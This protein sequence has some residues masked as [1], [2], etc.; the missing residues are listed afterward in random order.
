M[1]FF[2]FSLFLSVFLIS[3]TGIA[4]AAYSP[5]EFAV[6]VETEKYKWA[7]GM[8]HQDNSLDLIPVKGT[9]VDAAISPD[10]QR[11]AYVIRES[12]RLTVYK[13][14]ASGKNPVAVTY[15]RSDRRNVYDFIEV[16][17]IKN[18][19]YLMMV[20]FIKNEIAF[21]EHNFSKNTTRFLSKS[22]WRGMPF[23]IRSLD[24]V[25]DG[26]LVFKLNQY[27]GGDMLQQIWSMSSTDDGMSLFLELEAPPSIMDVIPDMKNKIIYAVGTQTKNVTVKN[28]KKSLMIIRNMEDEPEVISQ[29]GEYFSLGISKDRKSIIWRYTPVGKGE[30]VKFK[31]YNVITHETTVIP[32]E[33]DTKGADGA[34][35]STNPGTPPGVQ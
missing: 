7:I 29:G 14:D 5:V 2:L 15:Y 8:I 16:D 33:S 9:L 30:S 26:L 18:G 34:V 11:L 32:A 4:H 6:P 1:K 20:K 17:F 25:G 22:E 35:S 10:G 21:I 24:P 27:S 19:S 12:D 13:S 3:H 31:R 28:T 23:I